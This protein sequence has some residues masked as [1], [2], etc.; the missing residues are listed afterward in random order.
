MIT[1]R[2]LCFVRVVA[3]R[4]RLVIANRSGAARTRPLS[5]AFLVGSYGSVGKV[6]DGIQPVGQGCAARD[7][8]S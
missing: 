4:C 7:E 3:G 8:G 1:M 5:A 2:S 6:S